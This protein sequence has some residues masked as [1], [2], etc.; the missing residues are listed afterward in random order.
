MKS[1]K[2]GWVPPASVHNSGVMRKHGAP[3]GGY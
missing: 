3:V 2:G 1:E